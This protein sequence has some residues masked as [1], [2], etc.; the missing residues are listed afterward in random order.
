MSAKTHRMNPEPNF[1]GRLV[2][3]CHQYLDGS[4]PMKG[5]TWNG[6]VT[7]KKCKREMVELKKLAQEDTKV[8]QKYLEF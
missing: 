3:L 8:N 6:G 4:N 5:T 2:S 7:C 1:E